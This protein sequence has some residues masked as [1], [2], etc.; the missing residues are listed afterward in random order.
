[1]IIYKYKPMERIMSRKAL[2]ADL[3]SE[4]PDLKAD[5]AKVSVAADLSVLLA[6]SNCTR[7]ELAT[8][9]GWSRA[10]VTQVLS[11]EGNLTIETVHAVAQ[12]LGHTFDVVFRKHDARRQ[13]QPWERGVAMSLSDDAKVLQFSAK[14]STGGARSARPSVWQRVPACG[15]VIQEKIGRADVQWECLNAA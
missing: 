4:L 7:S 9:L 8:R 6:Q 14:A 11:G 10:R 13:P 2:F 1:V 12:A 3:Q 15:H 5:L